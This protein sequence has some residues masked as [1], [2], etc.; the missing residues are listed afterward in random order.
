MRSRSQTIKITIIP[1]VIMVY[2]KLVQQRNY[3]NSDPIAEPIEGW[4]NVQAKASELLQA[5]DHDYGCCIQV[6]ELRSLDAMSG[7]YITSIYKTDSL[8]TM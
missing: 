1:K 2:Y 5:M 3:N 6:Y 7:R 4:E 8:S